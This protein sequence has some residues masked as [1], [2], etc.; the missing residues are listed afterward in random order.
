MAKKKRK[1]GKPSIYNSSYGDSL[2]E[3]FSVTPILYK[4]I[5]ITHKDGSSVDK[6]EMEAAPTPYFKEWLAKVGINRVTMLEW[7]KKHAEFGNAYKR[8]KE[9]QREFIMECA[10]KG[11][12]NST[13][14]IFMMKNLCRWQDEDDRNWRSEEEVKH[15]VEGE[16][17]Q[18][19]FWA[20]FV[21]RASEITNAVSNTRV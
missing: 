6:T 17:S 7:T 10:L 3:F 4:D 16:I 8:A 12:H 5:T 19:H 14:S 18:R 13:F 21:K 11:V 15:T 1:V 2:V 9:M 20:S